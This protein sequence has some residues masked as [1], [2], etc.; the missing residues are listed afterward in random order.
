MK[1]LVNELISILPEERRPPLRHWQER[2]QFTVDWTPSPKTVK[3]LAVR[4]K[5]RVA[6][7][8]PTWELRQLNQGFLVGLAFGIRLDFEHSR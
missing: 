5:Q 6:K 4:D 7:I 2:L 1:A 3:A 8:A